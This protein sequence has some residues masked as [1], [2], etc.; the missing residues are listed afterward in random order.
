MPEVGFGVGTAEVVKEEGWLGIRGEVV[1][2]WETKG[3]G[4]V[5]RG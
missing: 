4:E 2:G 1:V 3:A 5:V